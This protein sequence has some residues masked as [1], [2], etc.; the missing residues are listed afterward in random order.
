MLNRR[1]GSQLG[2]DD[3]PSISKA[4]KKVEKKKSNSFAH[5][6]KLILPLESYYEDASSARGHKKSR[7]IT[8]PEG[9]PII[10]TIESNRVFVGNIKNNSAR[11]HTDVPTT[12][13]VKKKVGEAMPLIKPKSFV[14][15][16][17]IERSPSHIA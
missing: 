9:K 5:R 2:E 14:Q 3:K 4:R 17:K 13:S 8:Q 1:Q 16:Q 12:F 6:N 11:T 7:A 10:N 15:L